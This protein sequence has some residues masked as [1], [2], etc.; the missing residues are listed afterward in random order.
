MDWLSDN[1]FMIGFIEK[2][3]KSPENELPPDFVKNVMDLLEAS[4]NVRIVGDNEKDT[5]TS[6]VITSFYA[7]LLCCNSIP[8]KKE[9]FNKYIKE[10]ITKDNAMEFIKFFSSIVLELDSNCKNVESSDEHL[11]RDIYESKC[12]Q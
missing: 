5:T 6:F 10:K 8:S 1:K 2:M 4:S 11:L 12:N 7:I 3:M 9:K